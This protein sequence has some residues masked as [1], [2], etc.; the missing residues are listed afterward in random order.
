MDHD[1]ANSSECCSSIEIAISQR[2][3]NCVLKFKNY[4]YKIN[5]REEDLTSDL[6]GYTPLICAAIRGDCEEIQFLLDC[7]ANTVKT[8]SNGYTPLHFC[9]QKYNVN[10]LR[11]FLKHNPLIIN[12]CTNDGRTFLHYALDVWQSKKNENIK[13]EIL[14][15]LF[16]YGIDYTKKD[17]RG[18]FA[19]NCIANRKINN[20]I[21]ELIYNKENEEMIKEP[22]CD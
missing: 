19:V 6:Y 11:I 8:N 15:L 21:K 20:Y 5:K 14:E 13:K 2:H 22:D 17:I 3:K 4:I 12:I 9:I 7:G 16:D 10:A 18:R 1:F